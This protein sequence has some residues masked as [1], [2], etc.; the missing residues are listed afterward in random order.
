MNMHFL[1]DCKILKQGVNI[2]F[3]KIFHTFTVFPIFAVKRQ[4]SS[5]ADAALLLF[6]LTC[7]Q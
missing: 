6:V 7:P 5:S 1:G 4:D 3:K 2:A